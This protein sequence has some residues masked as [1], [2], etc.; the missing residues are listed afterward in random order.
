MDINSK[1]EMM[2]GARGGEIVEIVLNLFIK[3]Y[4]MIIQKIK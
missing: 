2:I 4:F 1:G 3:I